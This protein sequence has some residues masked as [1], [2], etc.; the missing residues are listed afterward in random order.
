MSDSSKSQNAFTLVEIMI[1]VSILA[2]LAAVSFPLYREYI[3]NSQRSACIANLKVLYGA[4]EQIKMK[5]YTAKW[6]DSAVDDEAKT[7]G[8]GVY[9]KG[10]P[11]KILCPTTKTEYADPGESLK[12]GNE[13][14]V[15]VVCPSGEV[16]GHV[17]P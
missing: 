3:R 2:V 6:D 11:D 12:A 17:Y 13:S 5:G 10:F 7:T 14:E 1:V 8:V 15:E 9:V 16:Y 4:V